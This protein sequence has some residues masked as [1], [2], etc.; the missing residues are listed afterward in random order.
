MVKIECLL[1]ING[2]V[3]GY[4]GCSEIWNGE[5]DIVMY[6]MK[7]IVFVCFCGIILFWIFYL[8]WWFYVMFWS[9]ERMYV[10]VL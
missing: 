4:D 6:D 8:F 5:Y 9:L 2:Y 3:F 10:E 1:W 7:L